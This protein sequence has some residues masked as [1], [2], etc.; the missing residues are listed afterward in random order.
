LSRYGGL[1]KFLGYGYWAVLHRE[2]NEF[3][4]EL[5]FADFK[6]DLGDPFDHLPEAGWAVLPRWSGQ[7]FA[8]EAMAAALDWFDMNNPN[9]ETFCMIDPANQASIKIA[10]KLGYALKSQSEFRKHTVNLYIRQRDREDMLTPEG[11]NL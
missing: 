4:G 6:R 11:R 7:G 1:W 3:V 9:K 5:G 2:T 8:T 10:S